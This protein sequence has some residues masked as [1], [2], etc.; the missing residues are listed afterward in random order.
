MVGGSAGG[1]EGQARARRG[2]WSSRADF[3]G[4][5]PEDD[6]RL[7]A[8]VQPHHDDPHPLLPGP[9]L[10]EEPLEQPHLTK[11]PTVSDVT[12]KYKDGNVPS[13]LDKDEEA[14]FSPTLHRCCLY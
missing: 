1:R 12:S 10:S 9:D 4:F 14:F 7:A 11:A 13:L 5:E 3:L 6:G 2:G 8:V